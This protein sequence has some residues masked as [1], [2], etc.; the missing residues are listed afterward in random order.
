MF[1]KLVINKIDNKNESLPKT[2]Y[3]PSRETENCG[4]GLVIAL[5]QHA[6]DAA[7]T[8]LKDAGENAWHIGSIAPKTDE[9]SVVI[10]NAK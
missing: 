3:D 10:N 9:Q 4:V 1:Y 5:P 6:V 8:V 2:V 7:L